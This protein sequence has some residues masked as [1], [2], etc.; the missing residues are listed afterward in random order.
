MAACRLEGVD[1]LERRR[2]LLRSQ[3]EYAHAPA[4]P[5]GRRLAGHGAYADGLA[6]AHAAGHP[7]ERRRVPARQVH[8]VDV[9]AHA[10]AVGG[11]V[12]AA[13]HA[14]EGAPPY[15]H[16]G[17]VGEQVVRDALRVLADAAGRVSVDGVEVAQ[18]HDAPFAVAD[19]EV[20]EDPLDHRLGGAVG[21]RGGAAR[22]HLGV[23]DGR[24]L[25]V[26]AGARRDTMFLQPCPS[27]TSHSTSVPAT[28]FQ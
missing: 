15:G 22:Q 26:R 12:V 16:L 10:R 28:L 20:G 5:V 2:G 25:P 11:G 9:V 3:V 6:G 23:G 17:H 7:V 4:R 1:R 8:H 14:D 19:V 13:E 27:A 24:I 18:Q 21:V